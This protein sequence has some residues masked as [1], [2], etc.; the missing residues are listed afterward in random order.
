R[1]VQIAPAEGGWWPDV[2]CSYGWLESSQLARATLALLRQRP[3]AEERTELLFW[4]T[5]EAA[6][7][8][9]GKHARPVSP[10]WWPQALE[11]IETLPGSPISVAAIASSIGVHPVHLARVCRRQL[12]CTL[13]VHLLRRRTLLAWQA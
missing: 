12:G 7:P 2:S 9:S 11:L 5:V 10:R 4:E 13:R 3:R 8:N 6:L 1:V